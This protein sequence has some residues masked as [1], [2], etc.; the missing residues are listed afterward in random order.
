MPSAN[1]LETRTDAMDRFLILSV[2][3][4]SRRQ[5]WRSRCLRRDAAHAQVAALVNGEPITALDIAQ[6]TKLVQL[7]TQKRPRARRCSMN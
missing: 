1:S 5:P 3:R 6:R 2:R 4:A 7:S